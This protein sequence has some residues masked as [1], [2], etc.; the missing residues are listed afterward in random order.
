MTI[1]DQKEALRAAL[2]L[3]ITAPTEEDYAEVLTMAEQLAIGLTH[4]EVETIKKAA[5]AEL[6]MEE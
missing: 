1:T 6:G 4:A 3:A 2:V 5:L